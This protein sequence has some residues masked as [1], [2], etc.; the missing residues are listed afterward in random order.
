VFVADPDSGGV[1]LGGSRWSIRSGEAKD[2]RQAGELLSVVH[3]LY[4][5]VK[6]EAALSRDESDLARMR[7]ALDDAVAAGGDVSAYEMAHHRLHQAILLA[8]HNGVLIDT[9]NPLLTIHHETMEPAVPSDGSDPA[10]WVRERVEVHRA[11]VDA[12]EAQDCEQVW[13]ALLRHGVTRED[14][15]ADRDMLPA[16]FIETLRHW[17]GSFQS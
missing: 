16:G 14:L 5:M 9:L 10:D 17:Q 7:A 8:T 3:T 15:S 12:I 13:I 1:M 11:I 6:A 4:P 2:R